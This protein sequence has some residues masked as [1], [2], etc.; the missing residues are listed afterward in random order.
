PRDDHGEQVRELQRL[1][2][3]LPPE[4]IISFEE[5][6]VG[7]MHESYRADFWDILEIVDG[8]N[9]PISHD[10]FE[11]FSYWLILYRRGTF[12]RVLY[13]LDV[14]ADIFDE[15]W[16]FTNQSLGGVAWRA[17]QRKTGEDRMPYQG[18]TGPGILKG[19][20]LT[21]EEVRARYPSL[22]ARFLAKER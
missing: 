10:T 22:W 6:F 13:Q 16:D 9:G 4:E 17:Y 8:H 7:V 14:L 11:Y 18:P 1:L 15:K 21:D 19:D 2:E 20:S 12:E 3:R 5:H